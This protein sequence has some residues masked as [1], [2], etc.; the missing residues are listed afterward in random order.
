MIIWYEV[1][2]LI[3]GYKTDSSLSQDSVGSVRLHLV[4]D[5]VAGKLEY[6]TDKLNT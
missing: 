2:Y 3:Y 5:C 4:K 6:R 1:S